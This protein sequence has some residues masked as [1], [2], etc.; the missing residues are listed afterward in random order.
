M[1]IINGHY[2]GDRKATRDPRYAHSSF[3]KSHF[4]IIVRSVFKYAN[5]GFGMRILP[6]YLASLSTYSTS[7]QTA[8]ISRDEDLLPAPLSLQPLTEKS[9]KW[10]GLCIDN[11]LKRGHK[12]RP[13]YWPDRA[14]Q[15]P[16]IKSDIPVFSHAMLE[17]N[18][19][20]SSEPLG[21]SCLTGFS[22]LMRHV[23]LWVEEVKGKIVCV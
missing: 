19:Q 22:L 3:F 11:Y 17:S 8:L 20:R 4:L 13:F 14:Q 10:T 15:F 18:M 9:R 23:A 7:K 2:L 21:R 6:S 12:S 16:A 5:K 1:D